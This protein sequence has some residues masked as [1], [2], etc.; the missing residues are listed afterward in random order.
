MD[1]A[2]STALKVPEVDAVIVAGT[3]VMAFPPKVMLT[4]SPAV[5][6]EPVTLMSV[7]AVPLIGETT[8]LAP[9]DTTIRPSGEERNMV[10]VAA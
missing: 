6:P 3:V 8:K 4:V 7:S 2:V 5:N 9:G 10:L 1:G